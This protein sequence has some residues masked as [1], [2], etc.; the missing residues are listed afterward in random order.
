MLDKITFVNGTIVTSDYLNE[1]QKGTDFSGATPRADYYSATAA[2]H[3]SWKASQ[4][5]KLKDYEI[6][7]PR[8]EQETSI[9]RLAHDGIILGYSGTAGVGWVLNDA[10]F[11]EPK[12]LNISVGDNNTI[13]VVDNSQTHGLIV[14]AG[15]ITLSDGTIGTWPRQIVGLI[16]ET[17]KAFIY[18]NE[19]TVSGV[20]SVQITISS[21]LPSPEANPYVPLAEINTTA[22]AFN[23]DAEGTVYGTGVIDL[24]PN[25]YV[26]ALNNYSTGVLK[27]TN[28]LNVNTNLKGW[29][30]AI[31]DTRNGSVIVTLPTSSSDNDRV[32]IVDLEGSFDRYPVVLRPSGTDKIN[33]SVDDW[34]VN[35]RD[36]HIELFYHEATSEWRFEET[37]GS[38]CNPKLGSFLSC[39]GKEYI[40]MRTAGECPDGQA[41]PGAYPNP[42]EGVYRFEAASGKCYK[43]VN[44]ITAIYSNGEGGLIKVFG[45]DRCTKVGAGGISAG[46]EI[47]KNIIYVDPAVG[48]DQLINNGTNQD[49]PFRTIERALLEASRAS[50]RNIGLDAYDT[51]VIELAPGDYYIDNSPGLNAVGGPTAGDTYIKQVSTGFTALNSWSPEVPYITIKADDSSSL[52]P[53]TLFNLGRSLYTAA[54][55]VGTIYKIEKDALASPI[56]RVYLQYVQ[57][58]FSVGEELRINRLSDYNP[59]SGGLVVPRGISINGVD[60]R[61][62]RVRPMYVPELTPGSNVAQANTTYIFKVTGGTYI[63]LITFTDNQQFSRTHNTV[64][65]IGYASEAEIKG[66]AGE[67]SYYTK[68]QSLFGGIDGW[69]IDKTISAVSAETTIVA[70]LASSKENRSEDREENQTGVASP[71]YQINTKPSYPGPAILSA[72]EGG[73]T[74]YFALP[75]VNSTRSSSPYVFNCSVRS[76]FGLN[77]M[78][79]DGSRVSGFKSMVSANYTQVS[80]QTD[81]DCFET[82]SLE[83]YNDPP[84]NKSGDGG[85][86][87]RECVADPLKYR[88]F[89]FRASYDAQ[90]Q[91]VSCFVIGNADH[92][93]S[94][95]GSDLSITNSCSDFGDISLRAIG[96][97]AAAFSQDGAQPKGTYTGT[98]LTQ[99]IPP[100]PLSYNTLANGRDATLEDINVNTGLVIEYSQTL[101]YV[102]GAASGGS[103]PNPMRIY[104]RNGNSAN[105]FTL[106][107]PPTAADIGLGQFSYTRKVGE[108]AYEL[109]GG[110]ARKNRNRIYINGFSKEGDAILYAGDLKVGAA[111]VTPGFDQLDDRS[112][113]FTWDETAADTDDDGNVIRQGYWYLEVDTTSVDEELVDID[114]DGYLLKK[115]DFAFQYKLSGGDTVQDEVNASL[116]FIFDKSPVKTI[117]GAD[118]RLDKE[119]V[120][121]LV[122][123]GFLRDQGVRRPQ[124]YYILEKQS[125]VA[126]GAINTGSE[127]LND[128]LT[129]TQ[130]QTYNEYYKILDSSKEGQFNLGKFVAYVTQGSKARDVFTGDFV[131][132]L[133]AD[134]PELTEDPSDSITKVAL[135]LLGGRPGVEYSV[136][137]LAPSTDLVNVSTSETAPPGF[138]VETRRPSVIRASGHT[139]EWT[140]YLNY[141]TS[142]PAFQGDPLEQD[143]A[144]GKIIVEEVAG[145]VYATGMNEEGNYYLGTTVFDLRSGEQFSIPLKADNEIGSVTNQVLNNVIIKGTLLMQDD[146]QMVFGDDTKI[147]FSN[148]TTFTSTAGAITA[149]AGGTPGPG[150]YATT[151]KAGLVELA[152][153]QDIR[154][155]FGTAIGVSANVA[156]TA[157]DLA[158][159]LKFRQENQI[160]AGTGVTVADGTPVEAPGGDPLDPSDDF[161]PR[162]IS[163]GQEVNPPTLSGS[164]YVADTGSNVAF[165]SIKATKDI[166]AFDTVAF[167]DARLKENVISLDNSLEKLQQLEGV[168][169][170][171]KMYPEQQ[172]IG[173]IAQDAG[174]VF[175]ELLRTDEQTG[176]Y[177]IAY[178]DLIPVLIESIKELS[179]KV[180]ILEEKLNGY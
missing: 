10:T 136:N 5:D 154:G 29:D 152:T 74:N 112:K 123:E 98:K 117:R 30:R 49:A 153:A 91:L 24:R 115:F 6:A 20:L 118:R 100:I 166:S 31:V 9:G 124:P 147:I 48:N 93:I 1:V 179:A 107:N 88:H 71:D 105:P 26:G 59:S 125:G 19:V 120:Y 156:V 132:T 42:S 95:S 129:V 13:S 119:R 126:G 139:W 81:P 160:Q 80:L 140:G 163:I 87:Y 33:N 40:G 3:N 82:P 173:L 73:T 50:R 89:G 175:P 158:N 127:L 90:V 176:M 84:R 151:E 34:I 172:R 103:T 76:I 54:G 56:W 70:P 12:T 16:D 141:D 97:K 162:K 142:F 18:A 78:W 170:N 55:A 111:E 135:N 25:L 102:L 72:S 144:L 121:K 21:I 133:N 145:R 167:S 168:S 85:K 51:T 57:G 146:S 94:E 53:P 62:V 46:S 114:N 15:K 161:I 92:F 43:E 134:E 169:Y 157:A 45:A 64:T 178:N 150:V 148:S 63:S 159:E 65:A 108:G 77:G 36:A 165:L 122:F 41:I 171:F 116:D 35:I 39:G 137:A 58:G 143:F 28:I 96:Y 86:R 60:L 83:Y 110:S 101:K 104:V 106:T 32:A 69:G 128:P 11:S 79:I 68:I 99:V 8:E 109:A 138:L 14:E 52:Q 75:D 67:T 7:N 113:V 180:K 155:A 131:P 177:N 37:P 27:N 38:E 149:P 23:T 61:K 22:G 2:D 47:I 174:K 44:S 164:N 66:G 4:R 17:G 130:V